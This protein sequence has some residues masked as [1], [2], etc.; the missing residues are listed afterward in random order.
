MFFHAVFVFHSV[1]YQ[2]ISTE[3]LPIH[4]EID[5]DHHH[6]RF[7]IAAPHYEL[8]EG[9]LLFDIIIIIYKNYVYYILSSRTSFISTT[10]F[11]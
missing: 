3:T 9:R 11:Q 5:E 4:H 6:H 7:E 2:P 10:I 1:L 8:L